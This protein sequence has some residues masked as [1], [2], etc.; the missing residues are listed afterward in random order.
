[1]GQGGQRRAVFGSV[2]DRFQARKRE[3]MPG[4]GAYDIDTEKKSVH[5]EKEEYGR[6]ASV[7]NSS[8]YYYSQSNDAGVHAPIFGS[9]T[10]RF[11]D[12]IEGFFLVV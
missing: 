12:K 1:M 9:Q 2:S 7:A 5:L 6:E 11:Q 4:P 3:V 10:T 8:L